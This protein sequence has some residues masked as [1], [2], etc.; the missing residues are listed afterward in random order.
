M[1]K[2]RH[3]LRAAAAALLIATYLTSVTPVPGMAQGNMMS[4]QATNELAVQAYIYAY[5]LVMMEMSRRIAT[6]VA[7]PASTRAPMGQF[8]F[9]R[10]YPDATFTDVVAPNADRWVRPAVA[11]EQENRAE[12]ADRPRAADSSRLLRFVGLA[13]VSARSGHVHQRSVAPGV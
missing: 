2:S 9:L 1:N 11:G 13:A 4:A 10:S 8:A 3:V 12:S 6:N 7:S 5:P